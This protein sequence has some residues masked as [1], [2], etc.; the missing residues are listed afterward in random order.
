[1]A[2]GMRRTTP[3]ASRNGSAD[4]AAALPARRCGQNGSG[5]EESSA[6]SWLRNTSWMRRSAGALSASKRNTSTGVVFDA[7]TSPQPSGQSARTPSI[8]VRR[9]G[10]VPK[11]A[12]IAAGGEPWQTTLMTVRATTPD[13]RP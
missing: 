6:S 1:M 8:V 9:A 2:T 4:A 10:D 13:R 12:G 3:M 11:D 5:N 7:R